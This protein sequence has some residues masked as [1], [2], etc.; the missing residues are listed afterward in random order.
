MI[1]FPPGFIQIR[2]YPGYYWNIHDKMLY[3]CKSGILRR[4][5]KTKAF[6]GY[7][8]YDFIDKP[9]GFKVSIKGIPKFVSISF[10]ETLTYPDQTQIFPKESYNG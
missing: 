2:R 10:L 4:L 9:E 5:T 8:S 3:S 1:A 7:T 6:K